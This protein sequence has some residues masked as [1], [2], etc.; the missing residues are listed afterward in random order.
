VIASSLISGTD[1]FVRRSAAVG[2]GQAD[3]ESRDNENT[4][5]RV[6]QQIAVPDSI[7]E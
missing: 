3:D 2:H 4:G 1:I 5:N 7:D 6:H